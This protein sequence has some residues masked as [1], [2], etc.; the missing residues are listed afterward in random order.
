MF[1]PYFYGIK[2]YVSY[3]NRKID[4]AL[5]QWSDEKHRKTLKHDKKNSSRVIAHIV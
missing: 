2:V 5:R 3:F 1:A 4:H